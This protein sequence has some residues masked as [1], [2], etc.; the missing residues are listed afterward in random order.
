MTKKIVL[1][2]MIV[3]GLF[4]FSPSAMAADCNKIE[5]DGNSR[6]VEILR[7]FKREY[8]NEE[9]RYELGSDLLNTK[10]KIHDAIRVGFDGCTG[11]IILNVSVKPPILPNATGKVRL[12]G[13]IVK[14]SNGEVCYKKAYIA[15]STI[16]LPVYKFL[17]NKVLAS[18]TTSD[19]CL[20]L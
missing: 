2:S 16:I 14:L 3:L 10:L 19:Q 15:H 11:H 6:K 1:S 4:Q 8:R 5:G 13:K 9:Y 17:F 12:E 20:K 7:N 18:F